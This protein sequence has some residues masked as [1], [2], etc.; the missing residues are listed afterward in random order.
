MLMIPRSARPCQS[1]DWKKLLSD[2]I[3]DPAEL[4]Q[5]L[6]LDIKFLAA[7]Q[8]ASQI[9]P[10]RVPSPYLKRIKKS[11][12]QD[13]LLL[14]VLPLAAE[15]HRALGFVKDPLQ[16]TH[17]NPVKGL[18]HKYHGRVLLMVAKAC[19]IHC[20]YCFRRHFPYEDNMPSMAEWEQVFAYIR[21]DQSI[22]EVI[23]SGGDPL[24]TSDQRLQFLIQTLA[25]IPHVQR[26][27]I[28]SRLP[29]MIPQRVTAELITALTETRLQAVM[30]LHVNHA[31][32]LDQEVAAYIK[33]LRAKGVTL[34]NQSV[35][36][37]GINDSVETLV[38]LSETL[39]GLGIL[40][41]YLHLLDRVD[42][43]AHFAVAEE[44]A[45]QLYQELLYSLPGFLVPRLVKEQPG[46][47]SKV[48]ISPS[49]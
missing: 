4:L 13:P 18:L 46:M 2:A 43:A 5:Y 24:A 39:F 9:F 15:T 7:A 28:H 29:I 3:I 30:V 20:R 40:P 26:L 32:E 31:H 45:K 19:A 16:E 35:L 38:E 21:Q 27:R 37:Q 12:P 41:Y 14:Q 17:F 25:T 10:L 36:L 44:K 8:Q 22:K 34:L 1:Q 11:D 6:D 49:L 47:L 23:L 48:P 42:G 33:P